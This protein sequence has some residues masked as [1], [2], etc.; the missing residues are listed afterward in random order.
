MYKINVIYYKSR[1]CLL[2]VATMVVYS[3]PLVYLSV[4]SL[5]SKRLCFTNYRLHLVYCEADIL[6]AALYVCM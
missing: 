3:V 5:D 1:W 6:A 4:I 2:L